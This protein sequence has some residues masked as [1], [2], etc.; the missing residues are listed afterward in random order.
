[1]NLFFAYM[2]VVDPC[3]GL[4]LLLKKILLM[5]GRSYTSMKVQVLRLQLK[6]Q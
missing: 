4:Y 5:R 2:A 6:L 3:D 1:M